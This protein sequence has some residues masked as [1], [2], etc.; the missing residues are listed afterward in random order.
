[1]PDRFPPPFTVHDIEK[2]FV[3]RDAEGF[4][5]GYFY[6]GQYKAIGTN[7]ELMTKKQAHRWASYLCRK[8]NEEA[9]GCG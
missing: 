5:V 4:T 3:V 9:D 7:L 8:A 2:A 1:M 6:Y